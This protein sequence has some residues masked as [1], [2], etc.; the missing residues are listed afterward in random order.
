MDWQSRTLDVCRTH[1]VVSS[2]FAFSHC[3]CVGVGLVICKNVRD[4]I[5]F[6]SGV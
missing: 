1:C 4:Y 3:G 5:N 2:M 6:D